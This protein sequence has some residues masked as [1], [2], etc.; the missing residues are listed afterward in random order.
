MTSNRFARPRQEPDNQLFFDFGPDEPE[1][2]IETTKTQTIIPVAASYR[3]INGTLSP[4]GAKTKFK[5]NIEAI[6]FLK[7]IEDE[8]RQ[9]TPEEQ[10]ILACYVGW[11]GIPQAFDESNRDWMKEYAELKAILTEEEYLAARGS[12]LNAHYTPPRIARLLFETLGRMGFRNGN[13]LEP[14]CG[15]GVF[16]GVLPESMSQS[17]L[18]GVELDSLTGRIAR[19]LYPNADITIDG[20]ENTGFPDNFFDVAIGNVPFGQYKVL[21]RE[22]RYDREN[23]NIHDFFFAK[24]IDKVRPGGIIAF[25]TSKWTMDKA[26]PAIRIHMAQRAALLGAV[27]L[28]NN[29]FKANAGTEVT[30]DILFLQKRDAPVEDVRHEKWIPVRADSNGILVNDYFNLHPE[31]LLGTMVKNTGYRNETEC[32][33]FE[34]RDLKELL[35]TALS[36]T[37]GQFVEKKPQTKEQEQDSIPADPNVR[38]FSYTV[39]DGVLYYRE[40]SVMNKPRDAC[41]AVIDVQLQSRDD[42]ELRHCQARLNEVY[43]RF[44]SSYG[45]VNDPSNA[46]AFDA[47]SSYYLLCALE[48]LDENRQFKSKS[49]MFAKRT[50]RQHIVPASVDTAQEALL[51]SVSETARVDL[52]YMSSLTGKT[53]LELVQELQNEIFPVPGSDEYQTADEYL[54]GNVREKLEIATKKRS[55]FLFPPR[56]STRASVPHGLSQSTFRISSMSFYRRPTTPRAGLRRATLP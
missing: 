34:G 8:N 9:A 25:I 12:T 45:R 28:P 19:Q 54:S 31:M 17:K 46:R 11:G 38:N 14:S 35:E 23:F 18:Y 22:H 30:A 39:V 32:L 49:D 47:D 55:Q 10:K 27:R 24:S 20:F 50:I 29:A 37:Q 41:R 3:I 1:K 44:V 16:F 6:R 56:T 33:P 53:E 4:G 2:P 5:R 42:A 26:N 48:N 43:D 52:P 51:L 7:Q 40:D 15:T 21:D 36:R 13:I